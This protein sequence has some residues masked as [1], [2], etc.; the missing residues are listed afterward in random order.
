MNKET[1]RIIFVFSFLF[2]I[3]LSYIYNM[4]SSVKYNKFTLLIIGFLSC[5]F[6][7]AQIQ[8]AS[9][10]SMFLPQANNPGFYGSK[11]G[12]NFAANYRH[13]WSK[14]EGQPGT[15]N[16]FTDAYI[17]Q[18]HGGAG[19]S[20][21]N[22]RLGAFTIT[23]LNAGYAF[24]QDIRKKIKIGIGLNAG[25]TVSKLD[26]TRLITPQGNNGSLND[27]VLSNQVQKNIR[28]NLAVGFS[29]IH[30]YIEFG[31]SYSNLI[32]A[33]DNFDGSVTDLNAKYGGV[34][35]TYISSKI[36][37]GDNFSVK[38]SIVLNTDFKELQTDISFMAG[39]KEYFA[40]GINVRGYNKKSFESLS[41]VIS[42]NPVKNCC[43]IYSF[44]VNLNKLSVAN[45]GSHEITVSY[46]LPNSKLFKNPKIVNN[47]RFL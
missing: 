9:T 24:V 5:H 38:P 17:P 44:D 45:K 39:Y 41:P 18:I 15:V 27:D 47:P 3:F 34:F 33:K 40:L 36:K 43:I 13:Q 6:V 23:S 1:D 8:P 4:S 19:L 29:I 42:V 12:I 14:L 21:S 32:N 31:C 7:Y 10:H 20:V 46:L 16:V 35:Q 37:I 30:K 26:G 2:F 22:D 25:L 11:E 28:P